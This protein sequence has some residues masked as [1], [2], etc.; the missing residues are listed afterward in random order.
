MTPRFDAYTATS[1]EFNPH[2][3]LAM[4]QQPGDEVTE[5]RGFHS[6]GSRVS[7]KDASGSEVGAVSY[8]G[9]QEGRTMIEVKGERSPAVVEAIRAFPHQATRLD[10]CVDWEYPGCFE[11]RL[12]LVTEC[13]ASSRLYGERRGDWD[14]P[15]LG[16][17]VYLGAPTSAVRF[18]LYEK[19]KQPEYR[20]LLR[21]DLV[22]AEIQI[23]PEKAAKKGFSER[24]PLECWG[25]SPWSRRMAR[26]WL[27]AQ[28][29]P[30][31]PGYVRRETSRDRALRF[32]AGQY[33]GHLRS[34]Y[35]DLGSWECVGLTLR[36]MIEETERLNERIRRTFTG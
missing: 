12:Q 23:R 11:D 9:R 13:K 21:P 3:A 14:M 33:G 32:M 15:E 16:R 18:R 6:F 5:G 20:H 4:I 29:D 25:V 27:L 30:C 22:R 2:Q 17:T 24:T 31:P 7:V 34:L 10:S 36:E 35:E 28:L 26:E 8:G 19:G 1:R